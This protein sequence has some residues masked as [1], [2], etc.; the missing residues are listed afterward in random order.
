MMKK[1]YLALIITVAGISVLLLNSCKM[2]CVKGSGKQTSETRK[3]NEFTRIDISGA[4]KINLKQDSSSAV[5]ITGDDNLLQYIKTDVDDHKLRIKQDK[6]ICSTGTITVNIGVHHLDLIK[7][8]GAVEVFSDGKIVT[9]DLHLNL[10]GITKIN[11]DLDAANVN[12]EASGAT[13]LMLKGQASSHNVDLSGGGKIQAFDFIVGNYNISTSGAS[14][15]E[16]NV[17]HD[18]TVNSSGAASIKY[19]G[20]PASIHNDKSGVSTIT[21][22]N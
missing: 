2:G 21:K 22:V 10:S 5:T 1:I 9:Q 7:A 12:T 15:C 17:L 20:N 4:F 8:S 16:I 14:D 13:E 6:N 18:L 11:M 3:V 19:K